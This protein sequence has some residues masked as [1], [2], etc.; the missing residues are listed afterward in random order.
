MA[1]HAAMIDRMDREIG[2][3]LEQLRNMNAFNNTFICFLSDNGASAEIMVRGD[4]YVKV[5]DFGLARRLPT[6]AAESGRGTVTEAGPLSLLFGSPEPL[7]GAAETLRTL[8]RMRSSAQLPIIDNG[9][10][11]ITFPSSVIII[12]NTGGK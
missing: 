6:L 9:R 2:R 7:P 5:L 3:V 11:R 4:G 12:T 10:A 8:T 1:I